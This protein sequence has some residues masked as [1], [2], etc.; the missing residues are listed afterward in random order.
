MNVNICDPIF[1]DEAKAEEH[2]FLSRWPDR[3]P[4][5]PHCGCTNTMQMGGKTQAGMWLC[6]ECRDKFT[7]R[8]GTVMERSHVPLH[9]WLLATHLMAASK[10]GMS[11]LQLS[12]MLGVTYK[13]AWFL[14]HRIR[15]AMDEANRPN[16]PLGGAGKVVE[17][18]EAFVGGF[19]KKRLSGKVAPKKKVMTLVERDGR[20]RSF[21]V[22]NIDHTNIRG[23]LVTNVH[24]SSTLM[25]DDARWYVNV[26]REF[27]KHGSTLHSNREFSRGDGHH[28]N[29]AENF[30]SIL[31][32]GVIGTYHHWSETHIHRYLAEFDLRYS[33]KDTTD[34]ERAATILKGMEGRRL[35][36]RRIG[37]LAA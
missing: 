8:T 20:A 28:S 12:R 13:T 37:A 6:R 16:E 3:E 24:R 4:I 22:T 17:S 15:E 7:V 31:K 32:R 19:K 36:Y 33:T 2:I 9:K 26:G 21:H 27:A 23:A 14:A 35:T 25:T 10:K 34:A 1:H 29:T 5:C 18:D 30:F 11:A